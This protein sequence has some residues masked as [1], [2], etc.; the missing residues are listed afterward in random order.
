MTD[1]LELDLVEI[2]DE[3]GGQ[4][5]LLLGGNDPRTRPDGPAQLFVI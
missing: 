3:I 1:R 5:P 4:C 2:A